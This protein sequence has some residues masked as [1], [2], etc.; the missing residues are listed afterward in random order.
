M[1]KVLLA[2]DETKGSMS[3]LSVFKRMV[4]SPDEVIL[5]HVEQLEGKSLMTGMLGDAE[6]STLKEA[7]KGTEHKEALDR[8]AEKILA[9]YKKAL[10]D[11]GQTNIKTIV[12][13]G[14]PADEI[15]M[16]AE[17]EKVDMIVMGCNGKRGLNRF[18]S[19]C[20]TKAVERGANVPVLVAKECGCE[21]FGWREAYAGR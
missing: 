16:V 4:K 10:E 19:G 18:I 14:N 5:L 3:V 2:V 13:E 9:Y 1:K 8:K 7:L 6:M 11:D 20:T 15:L 12:M 21:T 17:E